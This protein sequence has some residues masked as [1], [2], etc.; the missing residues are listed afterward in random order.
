[1]QEKVP[2]NYFMPMRKRDILARVRNFEAGKLAGSQSI[3]E[4]QHC[5]IAPVNAC[6]LTHQPSVEFLHN[7]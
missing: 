7:T 4:R 1:M 5:E 2:Q 3:D 6:L